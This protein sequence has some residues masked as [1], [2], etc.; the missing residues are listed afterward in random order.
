[1]KS[2]RQLELHR[3]SLAEI[4]DIMNAMKHLAFMETRKLDRFLSA[5]HAVLA[6]I[7][8]ATADLVNAFPQALPTAHTEA[9][10]CLLVGSERGFCGDFNE[11]LLRHPQ[12]RGTGR[13]QD[14]PPRLIGV[15]HKLHSH[16]ERHP[17]TVQLLEGASVVEE[18]GAVLNRLVAALATLQERY[19]TPRLTALYHHDAQ[20]PLQTR[21]L[22]PPF[23][24]ALQTA[25]AFTGPPVLNLP[26]GELIVRLSDHYLFA[27]LNE[28]LYSSLMAENQRRV[29]HLEGAVNHLDERA[30]ELTR[31]VNARHQEEIIEEIE[32]ILLSAAS[33]GKTAPRHAAP[34]PGRGN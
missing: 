17:H 14:P 7:E 15:G 10:I 27:A 13:A 23:Q 5:Q 32:V 33:L 31:Q 34:E 25:P 2:R 4:R 16:L 26:P 3:H 1:M 18:V 6:S 11:A 30:A 12:L 22:L 19:G 28:I 24:S 8:A 20:G 29:Q 9:N 21:T